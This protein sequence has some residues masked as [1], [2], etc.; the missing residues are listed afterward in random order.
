MKYL[1]SELENINISINYF[2]FIKEVF[3]DYIKYINNYRIITCEYIKKISQFQEKYSP[4]LL[5]LDINNNIKYQ[6]INTNHIY[7]LTLPIT[8]II[9]KQIENLNL[10]MFGIESQIN[11]YDSIIKE[12][13]I[14]F[15]KFQFMFDEARKDLLTKYR[16]I[17]NLK[18]NFMK[19]MGNTE[20]TVKR[21]LNK[22]DQITFEQIKNSI[23]ITKKIEKEYKKSIN[24]A[25]SYED[26]FCSMYE[27]SIVNIKKLTS[28]TSGKMKDII[29]DFLILLK[30]NFKMQLSEIDIYLPEL[31]ELNEVKTLENLIESSFSSKN[32]LGNVKPYKYKLKIF[33]NINNKNNE[34]LNNNSILNLEDGF[35]EMPTIKDE[36]ILFIFKTMKENF[37][38]IEDNNINLKTEEEKMKCLILTEKILSLEEK[39]SNKNN[40]PTKKDIDELNSLL[41][42][43]SN[44]VVFLQ[45]LS[46]YRIKGK[47]EL[48]KKTFDIFTK[49]FNTIINTIERDNDFHSIKNAIILSQTYY[50]KT[51]NNNKLY[52]Q[53]NIENNK[54][55]KSKSFWEE[56]LQ[57]SISKE[58]V[59]SINN[60]TKNGTLLTENKK[61]SDDKKSNI[62]FSQIL[63]Y[64]DNMREFGLDKETIQE[65]I[66]PIINQYKINPESIEVIKSLFK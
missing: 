57:Y 30:N 64:A 15:N 46:E 53:K 47:F 32:K 7:K 17:D 14:L 19:N 6:N 65:I 25:K 54:I 58:I 43:H 50:I 61:D 22:K 2:N 49:L 10:F 51:D 34:I 37:E 33:Q 23:K 11:N 52:L 29:I 27:N 35:E 24:T 9:D 59:V 42:I 3:D 5:K 66:Y 36:I 40:E 21:Y 1:C 4:K 16:E 41:D 45:K 13:D 44:R 8:K 26:N 39:K 55:F 60:D 56:F 48:T 12:K 31:N 63:P 62:A 20:D 38:L 18:D 28:E